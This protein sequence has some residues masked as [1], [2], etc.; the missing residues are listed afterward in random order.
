MDELYPRQSELRTPDG[1]AL[2]GPLV[3]HAY[4]WFQEGVVAALA[5]RAEDPRLTFSQI[6]LFSYLDRDGTTIAELARRVHVARQS[7]HQTVGELVRTGIV[8]VV[9][10]P[11]SARSR[12]VRP[13]RRGLARMLAAQA[14]LIDLE[15]DL[16]GR[17][18][19]E[20]VDLLRE[21][22]AAD[23]GPPGRQRT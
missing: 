19:A 12:L 6:E 13:T 7:A 23:W 20:R 3:R 21:I 8:E 4:R 18:G 22:L 17:L 14:A 10:H 1:A 16:V 15:E 2:I 9:P 11:E 5:G